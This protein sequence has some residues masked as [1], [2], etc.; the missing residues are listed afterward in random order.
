MNNFW[1]NLR[2]HLTMAASVC[3]MS[4]LTIILKQM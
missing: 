1:N 3:F 2:D 4:Q